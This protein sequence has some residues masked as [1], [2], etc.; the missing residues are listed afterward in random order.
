M[1][2]QS[3]KNAIAVSVCLVVGMPV[4]A[5]AETFADALVSAYNHSGLL[6]QNR[7]LLRAADEDVAQA[8]AALRPTLNYI[9]EAKTSYNSVTGNSNS[10]SLT[11]AASMTLFDFGRNDLAVDVAKET[12]LSTRDQ[13]VGIEQLVL[14]NAV[15]AYVA[16]SSEHQNVALTEN[17]LRVITQELRASR[18]RFEVGEITKT[19]VSIAEARLAAARAALAGA[20]GDV[21]IAR[22]AYR[23]AIGH[24]PK[25]IGSPPRA[26]RTPGSRE[27][28]LNIA[29]RSHPDILAAQRQVT[30]ADLRATM[31]KKAKLPTLDA[32][33]SVSA[34]SR[35]VDNT[36]VG[37]EL[38]G[39][40]YQGGALPSIERQ[41]LA[42]VE[43]ARAGLHLTRHEVQQNVGN[44]WAQLLVAHASL[45]ALERQV[46]AQQEAFEGVREEASLGSRTTLDVL[47]EEQA[48]LDARTNVVAAKTN[49][50]VAVYRLLQS[51]GLLTAD[52]LG[53]GV[54][55]Y[56]AAAYYKSVER[57]PAALSAQGRALDRV[58][59]GL[60]KE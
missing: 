34:I 17:N 22:E 12:V 7:A 35:G 44:A 58:L 27:E 57:A 25:V 52:H 8:V 3:M 43:A 2:Y 60:A 5:T 40:I 53:L 15:S 21:A 9:A 39:P 11:L 33:A 24:Y 30:I 36:S 49:R 10:L 6:D 4:A 48:L 41:A 38:K 18:D 31:A 55:S 56:D 51:M 42:G 23:A 13:L 47:N 46:R 29:L 28:A 26:P 37:I 32:S 1:V 50:Y 59:K 19:D 54:Q 14:L 20:Q 16:L 45:E